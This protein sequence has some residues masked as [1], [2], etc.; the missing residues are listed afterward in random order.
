MERHLKQILGQHIIADFYGVIE[1]K[2]SYVEDLKNIF[3]KI[4]KEANLRKVS[5]SY[6]QFNPKGATGI[7]LL[8][9]SHI[10]FHTQPEYNYIALDI[11]TCSS[12][13][14]TEKAF[15]LA[16]QFLKPQS[17]D[18]KKLYRGESQKISKYLINEKF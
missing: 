8:E 11:Y 6:H 13:E 12:E 14:A 17:Q 5:S 15:D 9:E 2:I 1:D 7:I 4:V 18:I 3:E 10:S 16:L